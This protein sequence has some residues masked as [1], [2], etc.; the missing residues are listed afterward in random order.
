MAN[1]LRNRHRTLEPDTRG[2]LGMKNLLNITLAVA[3]LAFAGQ[4]LSLDQSG[5]P[6]GPPPV[7]IPG[8]GLVGP[9]NASGPLFVAVYD[10]VT[11]SSLV[12][13]L[14]LGYGQTGPGDMTT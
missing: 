1:L 8:S 12:Q 10:P 2:I 6:V 13:Y 7:A 9:N 11:G 5:V 3:G 14:G 4:A